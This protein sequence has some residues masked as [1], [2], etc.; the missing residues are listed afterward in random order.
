MK[1]YATITSERA[2]KGQGGNEFIT[3]DI[4]SQDRITRL[5]HIDVRPKDMFGEYEILLSYPEGGK[6]YRVKYP[7]GKQ[8]KGKT[9]CET[10]GCSESTGHK[11]V[12][13]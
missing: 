3:V 4:L 11:C 2:S 1:L 10:Y 6:V 13:F 9:D 12:P 8:Q 7:K 5:L